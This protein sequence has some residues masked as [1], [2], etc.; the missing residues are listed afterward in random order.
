[1]R[2]GVVGSLSRDLV[3]GSPPRPGGGVYYAARALLALGRPAAVLTKCAG[4]HRE[5]LLSPL[6]AFGVPVEWRSAAETTTFAFSYD[7][8]QRLMAVESVGD[9]W[10]PEDVTGAL[11]N[12]HWLHVGALLRSDFAPETLEMLARGRTLSLDGQGLVRP[13]HVGPLELDGDFDPGILRHVRILKLS[14]EEAKALLGEVDQRTVSELGVPE[15]V[16]T[17]GSRGSTVFA[18]GRAERISVTPLEGVDPTGAGDSF[19]TGYLAA[20]SAG[21]APASAARQASALVLGLLTP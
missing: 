8:G 3:D 16:V 2:L 11:S 5:E 21:H 12:V 1:V 9:P 6:A 20:R 19:A 10:T 17:L 13:G 4:G 18:D 14:E 15:V 7:G